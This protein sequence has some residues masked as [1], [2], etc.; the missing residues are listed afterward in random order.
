M[1]SGVYEGI[2]RHCR[3]TPRRHEFRYRI[4]LMYLDLAELDLVFRG[5]W[6]WSTT[7][8]ALAWFRRADHL[9]DPRRPLDGSVRDLVEERLGRRPTGPIRLLTQLRYF[10][11]VMNPVSFY[12][13]F[14]PADQR[15]ESVVAE[16]HNTP[17]GERHC[18]VLGFPDGASNGPLTSRHPKEFHVSPF[19]EMDMDYSW[20]MTEPRETLAVAVQNRRRDEVLFNA[21]VDLRRHEATGRRLAWLLLRYPFPTARIIVAIYWQALLLWLK[22][23]PYVPHPGRTVSKEIA[24]CDRT[25]S[26]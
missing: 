14:D 2:V 15:V 4:Y 13:C 19:M 10:G 17:W 18:Y 11:Y 25:P 24:A 1:H 21:S 26:I 12:Y 22:K 16:V 3:F 23:I 20:R 9:G 8:P 7:R 6:L 5:R